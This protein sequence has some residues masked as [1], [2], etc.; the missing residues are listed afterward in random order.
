MSS[1]QQFPPAHMLPDEEAQN[2]QAQAEDSKTQGQPL[3]LPAVPAEG[4]KEETH[5][6]RVDDA[7]N[8]VKLDH[9]GPMVV[10][11]DGTLS[12]IHNWA[13]MTDSERERTAKVLGKRNKSRLAA[14]ENGAPPQ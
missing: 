14:L 2:P 5:E 9:L 13:N 1:V 7:A 8:V 4:S 12:R 3:A 6:L 11:S 10:N